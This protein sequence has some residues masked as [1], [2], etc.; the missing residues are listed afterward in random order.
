VDQGAERRKKQLQ[1][2][3]LLHLEERIQLQ[4]EKTARQQ[5]ELA[6]QQERLEMVVS[7]SSEVRHSISSVDSNTLRM[8]SLVRSDSLDALWRYL[9][10]AEE[11]DNFL[12]FPIRHKILPK[13]MTSLYIRSSYRELYDR[14][15]AFFEEGNSGF[16]LTGTPGIGKGVF[17][18]YVLWRLA[19]LE[20]PP[21]AVVLHRAEDFGII[22][23]FTSKGCFKTRNISC[24]DPF[25]QKN[26]TWYLT[27]S[28]D[29]PPTLTGPI[30]IFVAPP[31]WK[32]YKEF[33]KVHPSVLLQFLEPWSLDELLIAAP[34]YDLSADVVRERYFILGG[35]SRHMFVSAARTISDLE[36]Q[37][38]QAFQEFDFDHFILVASNVFNARRGEASRAS[39]KLVHLFVNRQPEPGIPEIYAKFGS[40]FI[41]EK[42]LSNYIQ[43]SKA[44]LV[45]NVVNNANFATKPLQ[46]NLFEQFAHQQLSKGGRFDYSSLESG[47]CQ[48]YHLDLSPRNVVSFNNIGQCVDK[49]SYYIPLDLN[50]PCIDAFAPSVGLFQMA[51]NVNHPIPKVEMAELV[52]A[53]DQTNLFF[54]VPDYLYNS[55]QKQTFVITSRK[56]SNQ[57]D[58]GMSKKRKGYIVE[59]KQFALCIPLPCHLLR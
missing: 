12:S 10:T 27:D 36:E 46:R 42:A 34:K 54:V 9:S 5:K 29:P 53:T 49:G 45:D 51:T 43:S 52:N 20:K 26:T 31:N 56:N 14:M 11:K 40:R 58:N 6:I 4:A 25:L 38:I 59:V 50:F 19:R 48:T 3:I 8:S 17:L 21:E 57:E 16:P 18:I 2:E 24:V 7:T 37:I 30:T 35:V 13:R 44:E 28:L 39:H 33:L 23:L 41:L 47:D 32:H 1:A 22:Y 15:L 55:I